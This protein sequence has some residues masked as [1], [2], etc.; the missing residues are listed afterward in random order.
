MLPSSG[1]FEL[2]R[3]IFYMV[4]QHRFSYEDVMA[5]AYTDFQVNLIHVAHYLEEEKRHYE[6]LEAQSRQNRR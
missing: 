1:L 5:M 6:E 2:T 4:K 3:S